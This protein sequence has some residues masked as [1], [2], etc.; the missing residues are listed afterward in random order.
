MCGGGGG[1]GGEAEGD[2]V[3]GMQLYIH[4]AM[5]M[6]VIEIYGSYTGFSDSDCMP[7]PFAELVTCK[8]TI[9]CFPTNGVLRLIQL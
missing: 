3:L 8:H 7:R 5:C 4:R 6:C 9:S 1:G 2:K